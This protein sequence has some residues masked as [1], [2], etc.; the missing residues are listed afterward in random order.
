MRWDLE[1]LTGAWQLGANALAG[2]ISVRAWLTYVL[3][4]L[5]GVNRQCRWC[6]KPVRVVW[7]E[8]NAAEPLCL[9]CAFRQVVLRARH[10]IAEHIARSAS[11]CSCS[12]CT[13]VRQLR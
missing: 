9:D 1:W 4:P 2:E 10:Q 12:W 8:P 13:P 3:C 7:W 6:A 11:E 5:L